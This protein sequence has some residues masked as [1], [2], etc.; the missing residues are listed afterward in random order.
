M[1]GIYDTAQSLNQAGL[2][3]FDE[4]GII[5]GDEEDT[6]SVEYTPVPPVPVQPVTQPVVTTPE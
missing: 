3:T 2:N 4:D 6:E 5:L 1:K